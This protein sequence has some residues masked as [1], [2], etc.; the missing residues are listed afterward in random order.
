MSVFPSGLDNNLSQGG[1]IAILAIVMVFAV[2]LVIIL[3]TE[4]IGKVIQN[5]TK[6]EPVLAS[7]SANVS[8][9]TRLDLNDE[10]ATIAALIASIDYREETKKNIRVVSVKEV[11]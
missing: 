2:L 7:A 3:I 11:R 9:N 10:D 6:D 8:N 4:L 5:V 1:A